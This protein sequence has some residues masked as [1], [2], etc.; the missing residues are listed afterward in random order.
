MSKIYTGSADVCSGIDPGPLMHLTHEEMKNLPLNT[1]LD[2][3]YQSP[4]DSILTLCAHREDFAISVYNNPLLMKKFNDDIRCIC[5]NPQSI[6]GNKNCVCGNEK[7]ALHK[8]YS[9]LAQTDRRS[10]QITL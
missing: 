6:R 2:M 9:I 10:N 7:S 8:L 5:A 3:G 4:V 1:L